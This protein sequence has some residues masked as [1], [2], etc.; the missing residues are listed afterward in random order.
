MRLEW[1]RP[2]TDKWYSLLSEFTGLRGKNYGILHET[3]TYLCTIFPNGRPR[4]VH[5]I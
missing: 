3:Q 1:K 5:Y 4:A 2:L